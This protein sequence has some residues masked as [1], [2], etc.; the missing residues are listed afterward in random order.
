MVTVDIILCLISLLTP[1]TSEKVNK[2]HPSNHLPS[3][4]FLSCLAS[5]P[6]QYLEI[7]CSFHFARILLAQFCILVG[8][9]VK[10]FSSVLSSVIVVMLLK[11]LLIC[12]GSLSS[13]TSD[14][15]W[16]CSEGWVCVLQLFHKSG[17]LTIHSALG[18]MLC[19]YQQ[20]FIPLYINSLRLICSATF[21]IAFFSFWGF[22]RVIS[23][24]GHLHIGGGWEEAGKERLFCWGNFYYN[25]FWSVQI[26]YLIYLG[27]QKEEE[28]GE[29]Y[30]NRASCHQTKCSGVTLGFRTLCSSCR[31]GFKGYVHFRTFGYSFALV[32][33]T[34]LF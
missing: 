22:S 3:W 23:D 2:A 5:H 16:L 6:P 26:W 8:S 15:L 17:G 29:N 12:R 4:S 34:H 25:G 10:G 24:I 18:I 27:R 33:G 7:A 28:G 31:T 9:S 14:H 30:H 1:S 13:V 21:Y 32:Q 20:Y 11:H 19:K